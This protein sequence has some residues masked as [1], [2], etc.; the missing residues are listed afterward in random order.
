MFDQ[1]VLLYDSIAAAGG[2][3]G[4]PGSSSE[5]IIKDYQ[6]NEVIK[7]EKDTIC[8]DCNYFFSDLKC[9]ELGLGVCLRDEAFDPFLDDI[10]VSSSFD[11][12]YEL[13]LEKRFNGEKAAC[14]EYEEPEIIEVFDEHDAYNYLLNETLKYQKVDDII[15]NLH[16]LDKLQIEEAIDSL[17]AYIGLG[18][19]NAYEGLIDYYTGLPPADSLEDVHVRLKIVKALAYKELD[20]DI[21]NAFIN[22]LVRTPSNNTTRKL[23]T[24]IFK[25]LGDCPM[26]LVN[27]PLVQLLNKRKY[28]YRLKKKIY[29][30]M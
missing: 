19:N 14:L 26:E 29:E 1:G 11:C 30:I 8:Q 6:L 12:C 28:S 9:P 7:V 16:S 13:Y 24:E 20:K 18:N 2:P 4:I 22:E 27:E 5:R 10:M 23:Y 21:V 17:S 25:L 15:E 3:G